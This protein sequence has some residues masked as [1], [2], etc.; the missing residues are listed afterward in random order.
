VVSGPAK[1]L[2]SVSKPLMSISISRGNRK[3]EGNLEKRSGKQ[4][5][6]GLDGR[7]SGMMTALDRFNPCQACFPG[8]RTMLAPAFRHTLTVQASGSA[9]DSELLHR[10]LSE[11]Y[12]MAYPNSRTD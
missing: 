11:N 6:Q 8:A 4:A 12:D 9:A 2:G 1:S 10:S 3:S 7:L 5:W